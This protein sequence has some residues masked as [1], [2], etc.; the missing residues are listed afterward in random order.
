V[1]NVD[2]NT[3]RG[4]GNNF[5]IDS[6]WALDLSPHGSAVADPP[7]D[8]NPEFFTCADVMLS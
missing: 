5:E 3:D 7:A 6:N 4:G 1:R 2:E 8:D